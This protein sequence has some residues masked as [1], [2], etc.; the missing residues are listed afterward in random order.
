MRVIV[1]AAVL[2]EMQGMKLRYPRLPA[3]QLAQLA[4]ARE[5]LMAED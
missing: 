3:G 5:L 1:S 2:H 4:A